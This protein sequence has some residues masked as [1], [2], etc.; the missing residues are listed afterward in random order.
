MENV[1]PKAP[2]KNPERS[3]PLLSGLFKIALLLS[4]K[5]RAVSLK[6]QLFRGILYG[7]GFPALLGCTPDGL[8]LLGHL[9]ARSVKNEA[10][11]SR[12]RCGYTDED[13]VDLVNG[14][15]TDP[16][17]NGEY[18]YLFETSAIITNKCFQIRKKEPI[19]Q[20]DC[21]NFLWRIVM[22]P[23]TLFVRNPSGDSNAEDEDR[24]FL[25]NKDDSTDPL[26]Q[27]MIHLGGHVP[28]GTRVHDRRK[29]WLKKIAERP[30]M[31]RG[32]RATDPVGTGAG[33]RWLIFTELFRPSDYLPLS[34]A[35]THDTY[36]EIKAEL[37]ENGS[38]A[39]KEILKLDIDTVTNNDQTFH[40]LALKK[41]G[42][43]TDDAEFND[44]ASALKWVDDAIKAVCA[45]HTAT[46]ILEAACHVKL[47]CDM[48][49][50]DTEKERND[51]LRLKAFQRPLNYLLKEK[52]SSK[53]ATGAEWWTE[54]IRDSG[55]ESTVIP[56]H[57]AS[58][59]GNDA[60]N[61][62]NI[63]AVFTG[64]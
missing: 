12:V 52:Y 62:C 15:N 47:Y 11:Q 22:K 37:V 39:G 4:R 28:G 24:F 38:G 33:D 31:A 40:D 57:T 34:D 18:C 9:E 21:E 60:N 35:T 48:E 36:A 16:S 42:T 13:G 32:V 3:W 46:G 6:R 8:E 56:W 59:S 51:I 17:T 20:E 53:P 19:L 25:S 44:K 41:L 45:D 10:V 61:L 14:Y 49:F 55:V 2:Q 54:S 63:T 1:I 58:G 50:L 27:F 29:A 43:Y 7:A 5:V 26:R 23:D 30:V 64:I